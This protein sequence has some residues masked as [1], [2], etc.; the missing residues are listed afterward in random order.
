MSDPESAAN[1]DINIMLGEMRGQLR[2]MI[3]TVNNISQKQDAMSIAVIEAKGLPVEVTALRLRVTALETERNKR[4]GATGVISALM[5][6]PTL[7]WIV[8]ALT[9]AWAI[10]TGRLHL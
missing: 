8:G 1:R 7:G 2:E 5:R 10:V 6:S 4:D 9:T 3:H